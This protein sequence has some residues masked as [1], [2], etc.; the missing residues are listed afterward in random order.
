[1]G[2]LQTSLPRKNDLS[3]DKLLLGFILGKKYT[4]IEIN[5]KEWLENLYCSFISVTGLVGR[6]QSHLKC[7]LACWQYATEARWKP[8]VNGGQP[9]PPGRLHKSILPFLLSSQTTNFPLLWIPHF[10]KNP[11][12]WTHVFY[13]SW[14]LLWGFVHILH[15]FAFQHGRGAG[16]GKASVGN[17]KAT[18]LSI[19]MG[20]A[21]TVKTRLFIPP[22][23]LA[24]YVNNNSLGENIGHG[25]RDLDS[26]FTSFTTRVTC[27]KPGNNS[28]PLF[29]HL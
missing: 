23:K 2:I 5:A 20:L 3:L 1:M 7:L 17:H 4:Y 28:G 6:Q 12:I 11:Q 25:R 10:K 19:T 27:G 15:E 21:K 26:S 24:Q 8:L 14:A 13:R 9:Q 29:P 16:K 18:S 22:S